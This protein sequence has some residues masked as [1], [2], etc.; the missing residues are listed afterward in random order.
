MILD[1]TK[2]NVPLYDIKVNLYI[3]DCPLHARDA[4]EKEFKGLELNIDK[5]TVG[6]GMS[7]SHPNSGK[8]F[9]MILVIDKKTDHKKLNS[10]IAHE[11]LHLS[12]YICDYLGIIVDSNNHEAQAYIMESIFSSIAENKDEFIKDM[13]ASE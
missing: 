11:S 6:Y 1:K 5:N 3:T 10:I 7:I 9:N 4:I 13:T 12:Y 8:V 2:I